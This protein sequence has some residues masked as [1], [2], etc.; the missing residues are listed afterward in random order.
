MEG[1]LKLLL[2]QL[3]KNLQINEF[4]KR[5]RA[6]IASGELGIVMESDALRREIIGDL[7]SLQSAMD[8]YIE[9][10]Q[11]DF[12]HLSGPLKEQIVTVSKQLQEIIHETMA[13]DRENEINLRKLR[14]GLSDRIEEIGRGKKAL[15]GYKNAPRKAP[16]LFDGAV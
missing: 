8:P 10:L 4:A 3:E 9:R 12:E 1:Y 13:I 16:K 11:Q 6:A 5:E 2:K 14:E 7:K 15:N